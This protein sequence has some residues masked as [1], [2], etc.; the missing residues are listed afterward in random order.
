MAAV[1]DF[2]TNVDWRAVLLQRQINDIDRPV[3]PGTKAARIGEVD[4]HTVWLPFPLCQRCATHLTSAPTAPSTHLPRTGWP[5]ARL[6]TLWPPSYA[7]SAYSGACQK[8]PHCRGRKK[9]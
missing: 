5:S 6:D 4:F 2:V 3:H 8:N 7:L 1:D 9:H